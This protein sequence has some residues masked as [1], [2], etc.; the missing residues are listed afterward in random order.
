MG[1]RGGPGLSAMSGGWGQGPDYF[2]GSGIPVLNWQMP[3][4]PPPPPNPTELCA[5]DRV[6]TGVSS[7][8]PAGGGAPAVQPQPQEDREESL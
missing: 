3:P 2:L 4:P 7:G 8:S 1:R 5:G 6:D